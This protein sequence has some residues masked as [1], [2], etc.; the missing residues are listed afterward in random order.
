MK[1]IVFISATIIFV[2]NSSSS[3]ALGLHNGS[4]S[5]SFFSNEFAKTQAGVA[6]TSATPETRSEPEVG[7]IHKH[8][9]KS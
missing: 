8:K 7:K 5:R 2:L 3:F 1:S 9:R 4:G 6:Q